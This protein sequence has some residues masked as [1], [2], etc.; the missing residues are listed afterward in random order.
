MFLERKRSNPRWPAII[1]G[2]IY[3]TPEHIRNQ[4]LTSSPG[5]S[6]F[7]PASAAPSS[8]VS[9]DNSGSHRRS[10]LVRKESVFSCCIPRGPEQPLPD[11]THVGVK[12]AVVWVPCVQTESPNHRR[13]PLRPQALKSK[14]AFCA[15]PLSI[16]RV[17]VSLSRR[18]LCS[19]LRFGCRPSLCFVWPEPRIGRVFFRPLLCQIDINI[20]PEILGVRGRKSGRGY[21]QDS[22]DGLLV[23][24]RQEH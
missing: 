13:S 21:E 5:F 15:S 6:P 23:A 12:P 9:G 3:L 7:S 19:L 14:A 2:I 20:C 11:A 22:A 18:K 4:G 24:G 10:C 8:S 1:K 17:K 16:D